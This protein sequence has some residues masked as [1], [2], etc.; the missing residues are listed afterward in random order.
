MT[1]EKPSLPTDIPWERL[2]V[3]ANMLDA[4]V[5]DSKAPPKWNSSLAIWKYVPGDEHQIYP[6]RR[7][8]YL[9]LTATITGYQ[10]WN[11]EVQG[12]LG[13][14]GFNVTPIPAI[15]AQLKAYAPCTGALIQLTVGP[16]DAEGIDLA[17]YPYIMDV[18]PKKRELYETATDTSERMSRTLDSTIVGKA[19]GATHSREVLD[20]DFGGSSSVSGGASIWGIGASGSVSS[21]RHGEWG[22]RTLSSDQL[23][24]SRTTDEENERRN[25]QSHTTQLAQ[26]YNLFD[27]YHVGTNRALFFVQ[28]R[29]H[30]LEQPSGFVR[31][32][33]PVEGMQEI[34]LV[35]NQADDQEDF[36]VSARLDTA[37]L[38]IIEDRVP[39]QK[40]AAVRCEAHAPLPTQADAPAVDEHK[41]FTI[42]GKEYR[43]AW[44]YRCHAGSHH[45]VE[46]FNALPGFRIES[47]A[48]LVKDDFQ[49]K[50]EVQV[51]PTGHS[52]LIV[53]DAYSHLCWLTDPYP[54]RELLKILDKPSETVSEW[55]GHSIRE[56]RVTMTS[57]TETVKLGE[58]QVMFVTTRGICCC[59]GE[60][61]PLYPEGVIGTTLLNP[62]ERPLKFPLP[63]SPAA[64][65]G[66]AR[67][68]ANDASLAQALGASLPPVT[69]GEMS[70]RAA[71]ELG[72][73]MRE[74]LLRLHTESI[75]TEPVAYVET[76]L[77]AYQL[78]QHLRADPRG[79]AALQRPIEEC[80]DA[81]LGARLA[82]ALRVPAEVLTCGDV[83]IMTAD[84]LA[85]VVG[86]D[87]AEAHQLR[88]RAMGATPAVTQD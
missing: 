74:G 5:C 79:R 47:I 16:H 81:G 66:T 80:L 44:N 36:C 56:I 59:D 53:C 67:D 45:K 54:Q 9:K 51:S 75:G 30:V 33:R 60:G 76:D 2:C 34:F 32:P 65:G 26:L 41:P 24:L 55:A 58:R 31:G 88:L 20:V 43:G 85:E 82:E 70:A 13:L 18:Q 83:A 1:A 22:T 42:D 4:T 50:S 52:L 37:H 19:S 61:T 48:D 62:I 29:P 7:I 15:D 64:L 38:T 57:D 6:G 14:L 72:R 10:P 35:I 25:T 28:P 27:A 11:M 84:A 71:N 73:Q 21:T 8:T 39:V 23:S 86:C 17:D 49:G 69:A 77:F 12:K 40:Y 46:P 87:R 78:H 63:A 3:S 68:S